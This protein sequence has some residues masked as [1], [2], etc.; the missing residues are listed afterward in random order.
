MVFSGDSLRCEFPLV[1][2]LIYI[3]DLNVA[4]FGKIT[5]LS[6]IWSTR[7]NAIID[8]RSK[9]ERELTLHDLTR[10]AQIPSGVVQAL[11]TGWEIKSL[12]RHEGDLQLPV[13]GAVENPVSE[14]ILAISR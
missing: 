5:R 4:T 1:K 8:V 6:D 3:I 14:V 9:L 13:E 12:P 7:A 2:N 11:L 10:E